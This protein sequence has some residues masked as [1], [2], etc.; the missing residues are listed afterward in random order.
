MP[1]DGVLRD[2]AGGDHSG[3]RDGFEQQRRNDDEMAVGSYRPGA[4]AS[5]AGCAWIEGAWQ[6]LLTKEVGGKEMNI[7][8]AAVGGVVAVAVGAAKG[9]AAGAVDVVDVAAAAA[10]GDGA[11]ADVAVVDDGDGGDAAPLADLVVVDDAA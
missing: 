1:N 8:A 9:I 11:T 5:V 10:V 4:A 6:N 3:R 2:D 7:G